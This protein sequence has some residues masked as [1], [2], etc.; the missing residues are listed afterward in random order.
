MHWNY[1]VMFFENKE[2][3]DDSYHAIHE[4]YYDD[5]GAPMSYM[6]S[7]MPVLWTDGFAGGVEMIELMRK[8]FERPALR[9]ED[10]KGNVSDM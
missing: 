10:F 3:A 6:E 4:V 7:A 5:K 2:A 8:A 1:R 9:P